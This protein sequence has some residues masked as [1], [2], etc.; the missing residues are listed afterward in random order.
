MILFNLV[1]LTEFLCLVHCEIF[2]VPT[3]FL[4][5]KHSIHSVLSSATDLDLRLLVRG[6][7][8]QK[9]DDVDEESEWEEYDEEEED[10]E[11]EAEIVLT[12]G[13]ADESEND[14]V[15]EEAFEEEVD[16]F[17]DAI[18]TDE[19][20]TLSFVDTMEARIASTTDDENSSAFVDRMELADAYDDVDTAADPEDA[21]LAAVTASTAIGGG[22]DEA[23]ENEEAA[24]AEAAV[25][26]NAAV[27][28]QEITEDMK[29]ALK[30]LKY[31][32]REVKLMRPE[33]ASELVSKGLQR[34]PEGIPQNWYVEGAKP[35]SALRQNAFKMALALVALGGAAVVGLKGDGL[36]DVG[37]L[38][39]TIPTVLKSML[40]DKS[41]SPNKPEKTSTA[42]TVTVAGEVPP[43]EVA[44][45]VAEK[46]AAVTE[47]DHP[48]SV[49]PFSHDAPAYEENLDK[50]WLDKGITKIENLFKAFFNAKI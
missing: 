42:G 14:E 28:I 44:E 35:L 21:T 48:H 32:S 39:G 6:G 15:F 38:L 29:K 30:D 19:E 10:D 37:A 11:E 46:E 17:E 33:V 43:S 13:P 2:A 24:A 23:I 20:N 41:A 45:G 8:D 22:D 40:P 50:T 4:A 1:L 3:P 47:E 34:P 12:D 26:E 36:P 25:E 49:K 5:K 27:E 7:S 16:V 18:S 31:K 9:Y